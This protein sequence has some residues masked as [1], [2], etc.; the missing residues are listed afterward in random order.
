MDISAIM[1][2]SGSGWGDLRYMTVHYDALSETGK[3]LFLALFVLAV[4]AS[5]C[6]SRWMYALA[7]K[8]AAKC[9][10]DIEW[11]AVPNSGYYLPF[12]IFFL[13]MPICGFLSGR[14][15]TWWILLI[16]GWLAAGLIICLMYELRIGLAVMKS[17]GGYWLSRRCGLGGWKPV[18]SLTDLS[19]EKTKFIGYNS[20]VLYYEKSGGIVKY[21]CLSDANFPPSALPHLIEFIREFKR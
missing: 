7:R 18:S 13:L 21:G 19:A 3:W 2:F 17:K 15:D 11:I 16:F 9:G 6:S 5:V 1:A 10:G 12:V 8:S 20:Y 4:I 14:E